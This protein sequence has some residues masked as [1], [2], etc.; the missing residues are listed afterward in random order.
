MSRCPSDG[1]VLNSILRIL[2][3]SWLSYQPPPP[4]LFKSSFTISALCHFPS[5]PIC[6][7]LVVHAHRHLSSPSLPFHA[8][9]TVNL[10]SLLV[11][12]FTF[13]PSRPCYLRLHQ[14]IAL[15]FFGIRWCLCT[16]KKNAQSAL[17]VHVSVSCPPFSHFSYFLPPSQ[18]N[19]LLSPS[20]GVSPQ[21]ANGE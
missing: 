15:P 20:L 12:S 8:L 1:P 11:L 9:L 10:F 7:L 2:S 13:S 16:H 17:L 6:L 21:A 14:A 19:F 4:L 3:F 18:S 5:S